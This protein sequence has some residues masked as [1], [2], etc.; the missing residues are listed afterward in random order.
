MAMST[1]AKVGLGAGVLALLGGGLLYWNKQK[2]ADTTALKSASV[3]SAQSLIAFFSR[4]KGLDLNGKNAEQNAL[5]TT[6]QQAWNKAQ[7]TMGYRLPQLRTDGVWDSD[8]GAVF[9]QLTGYSPPQKQMSMTAGLGFTN[10]YGYPMTSGE[11][12]Q[13]FGYARG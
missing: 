7:P 4:N 2:A 9:K 6:F 12:R 1:A 3:G 8:T 13:L 10:A 11:L 5:V